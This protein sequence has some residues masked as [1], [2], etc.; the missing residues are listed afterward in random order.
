[1]AKRPERGRPKLAKERV[2]TRMF[3]FRIR[4]SEAK[5]IDRLA[6]QVDQSRASIVRAAVKAYLEKQPA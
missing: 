3:Y 6:K 1:M 4:D 5:A 2:R